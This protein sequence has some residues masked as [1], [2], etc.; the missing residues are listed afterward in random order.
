MTLI[1]IKVLKGVD[2]SKN[3]WYEIMDLRGEGVQK[4]LAKRKY[5]SHRQ[6]QGTCKRITQC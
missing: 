2:H 1:E 5:M 4:L 3:T 6:H